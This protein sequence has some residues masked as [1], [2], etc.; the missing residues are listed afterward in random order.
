MVYKR[1]TVQGSSF[2]MKGKRA[3]R[4]GGWEARRI[5]S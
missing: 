2:R 3:G 1:F 4:P 5:E